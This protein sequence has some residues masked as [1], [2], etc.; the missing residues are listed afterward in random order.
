MQDMIAFNTW[1]IEEFPEF[2]MSEPVKYF[3][4]LIILSYCIK[5][6]LSLRRTEWKL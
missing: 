2:L 6:I 3:V 1:F 5:I 4:G